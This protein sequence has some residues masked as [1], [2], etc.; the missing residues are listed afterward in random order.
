MPEEDYWETLFDVPLILDELGIGSH[1]RD[2]A[3]IGCGFGTFSI[4]IAQRISGKLFAFDIDP[5]MI[6]RTKVR[7]TTLGVKNVVLRECDVME[8]GCGL[9]DGSVDAELLFN[10]LHCEFP[11]TLLGYA[12]RA[13]RTGGQ[14]L[15]IHWK[16]D[17][18]TPRGPD[19]SIRP[20]PEQIAA[21][22]E[23]TGVLCADEET[24]D[25]PP[26]HFGLKLVRLNS[27]VLD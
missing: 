21:W 5:F 1:L 16:H 15:V 24:I 4:P 22:A 7:A 25:L 13:V 14:I 23:A 3:E 20:R 17:R 6:A 12:A 26:W 19:L 2:V 10:I 18:R 11:A 8:N 9:S 27:K